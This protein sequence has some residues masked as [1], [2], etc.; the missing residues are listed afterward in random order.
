MEWS[1]KGGEDLQAVHDGR[2]IEHEEH[3]VA[4]V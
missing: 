3:F 2:D 1:E 4:K